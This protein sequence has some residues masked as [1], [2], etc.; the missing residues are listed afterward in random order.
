MAI[1][2]G[3]V[4]GLSNLV[5]VL[6]PNNSLHVCIKSAGDWW[7]FNY[8]T[9][10]FETRRAAGTG[11]AQQIIDGSGRPYT[12]SSAIEYSDITMSMISYKLSQTWY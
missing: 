5:C 1:Y 11:W 7:T 6:Y 9:G 3:T 2:T 12:S 8:D 4:N 10:V